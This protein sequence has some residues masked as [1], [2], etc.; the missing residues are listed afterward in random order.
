[1]RTHE[2]GASLWSIRRVVNEAC[3][4]FSGRERLRRSRHKEPFPALW[5][6]LVR[7]RHKMASV[8]RLK[9]R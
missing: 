9:A 3:A 1:M 7:I 8:S 5:F 2:R 4:A 6:T